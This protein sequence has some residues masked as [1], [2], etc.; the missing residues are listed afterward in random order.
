MPDWTGMVVT[1][2]VQVRDAH[3]RTTLQCSVPVQCQPAPGSSAADQHWVYWPPAAA[4][5]R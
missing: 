3:G 2:P 4:E 5:R 1:G